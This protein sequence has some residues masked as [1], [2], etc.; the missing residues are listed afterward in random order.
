MEESKEQRKQYLLGQ[1]KLYREIADDRRAMA[2]RYCVEARNC[3]ND[4]D[5]ILNLNN[6]LKEDQ[7]AK[8]YDKLADAYEREAK[9]YE[10]NS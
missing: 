5:K 1:V 3:R 9:A 7:S 6:A 8:E 10:H 4:Y 2:Q